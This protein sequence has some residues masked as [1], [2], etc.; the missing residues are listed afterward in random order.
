MKTVSV[1]AS[2]LFASTAIAQA[3]SAG[4]RYVAMG[5][6]YA[7]GPG[8]GVPDPSGT[9]CQRSSSNFAHLVAEKHHLNLVDVSCS[10]AT[11]ENILVHGQ[12]GLPAQIEAVTPDTKLVTILIGGNDIDY[13]GDLLGLSCRDTGK[14]NCHVANPADI[15][16][17]MADLPA[18]LDRVVAEVRRRAPEAR[19]VLV[20]YL[21]AV[22][23]NSSTCDAVPLHAD[24]AARVHSVAVRLAQMIGGAAQRN[25]TGIVR[26]A[27]LGSGHDAC[28]SEPYVAGY[29]PPRNPGWSSP[30]AYHPNQAGMNAVA[31]ALDAELTH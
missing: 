4:I 28:S 31:A 7:A 2:L 17:K 22:P 11:T 20:G 25:H 16:R 26:S 18:S 3:P 27:M 29:H 14:P 23:G 10:S 19:V 24:D 1:L 13:V 6:S 30:I 8:V 15:E 5:S 12:H 21:P 9:S